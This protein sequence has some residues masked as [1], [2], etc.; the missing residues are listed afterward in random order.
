[1]TPAAAAYSFLWCVIVLLAVGCGR[2]VRDFVYVFMQTKIFGRSRAH[3]NHLF[4][5]FRKLDTS[6]FCSVRER[7]VF[8]ASSHC[9]ASG[10]QKYAH[11]GH[12]LDRQGPT[13]IQLLGYHMPD[14]SGKVWHS[15]G[16]EDC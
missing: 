3:V 1:M 9:V 11:T 16:T 13:H 2:R 4:N 6:G 5:A 10:L 12:P 15:G 7:L 14:P 8:A